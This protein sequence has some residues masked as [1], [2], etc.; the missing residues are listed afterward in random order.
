MGR[1][2]SRHL[3]TLGGRGQAELARA[4]ASARA[5]TVLRP[6]CMTS[7]KAD[8]VSK[9]GRAAG[10]GEMGHGDPVGTGFACGVIGMLWG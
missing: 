9:G 3:E 4:P 2:N 8:R 7:P 10:E 1:T 5:T 6:R